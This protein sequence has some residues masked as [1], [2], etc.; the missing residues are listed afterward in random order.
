VMV[1]FNDSAAAEGIF[2]VCGFLLDA[3]FQK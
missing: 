1:A 3:N 2:N